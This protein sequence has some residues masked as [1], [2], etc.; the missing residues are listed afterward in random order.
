MSALPDSLLELPSVETAR[1]IALQLVDTL[2][3]ARRRF[4]TE[5]PEALHD[6]RV[7]LRKLRTALRTYRAQLRDSLRR[8]QL[9]RLS[10]LAPATRES[11]DLEVHL[12]WARTQASSLT[13][14]ERAG[15]EWLVDR[16]ERRRRAADARLGETLEREF[17]RAL[18]GLERRLSRYRAAIAAG[19]VRRSRP[20]A[21]VIGRRIERLGARLEAALGQVRNAA[22]EEPAH[23]ARIAAKRLRYVLEPIAD[24]VVDVEP[25]IGRL[26]ALQDELGD[27]HDSHVFAAELG[28]ATE[29]ASAAGAGRNPSAGLLALTRRLR[30]R[31][32]TAFAAVESGWL[33]GASDAFFS[34]VE[35]LGSRLAGSPRSR[36]IERKYLLRDLPPAVQGSLA[37]EIRQGYLPG[38]RLVERVREVRDGRGAGW[39]RTVKSGSGVS[40]VELE[41]QTTPDLF[42]R[43]WPL[44]A[45][46]QVVKRRYRMPAG[47]LTW[48]ID[49]FLDRDL[50]LAEVELPT[51]DTA[52]DPP[53]WLTPYLDREVTDEPAYSNLRLAR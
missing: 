52:V 9:R 8:R 15:V 13:A 44:T 23:R 41:E 21:E 16:L 5:D 11:R 24:L 37:V 17:E 7:A 36:E 53:A 1:L 45:G 30:E 32:A 29:D 2:R 26:R 35:A 38:T 47:D 22:D 43:L 33:H 50:V 42:E 10:R 46:R 25:L 51:P 48:E 12:D 14:P 3:A 49:R 27:L 40:R 18:A 28:Q 31:G 34:E 39:W 19:P 20:A 6:F 4:G